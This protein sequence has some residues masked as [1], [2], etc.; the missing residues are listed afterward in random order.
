MV[1]YGGLVSS[2]VLSC[3][4]YGRESGTNRGL[5]P[6]PPVLFS[7]LNTQPYHS[8]LSFVCHQRHII[9]A[10]VNVIDVLKNK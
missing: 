4:I 3:G 10:A 8:A 9:L 7:V 5:S 1:K 2:N 6:S